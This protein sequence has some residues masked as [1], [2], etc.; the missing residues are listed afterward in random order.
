VVAVEAMAAA[1]AA[2]DV[3]T[4]AVANGAADKPARL[5]ARLLEEDRAGPPI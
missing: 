4:A 3:A 1:E 5:R 2:V